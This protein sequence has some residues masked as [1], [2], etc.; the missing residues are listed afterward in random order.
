M[1]NGVEEMKARKGRMKKENV[2]GREG[3]TQS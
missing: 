3:H 2:E 1:M